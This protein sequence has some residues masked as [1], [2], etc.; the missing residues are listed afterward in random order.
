[1]PTPVTAHRR[2][3]LEHHH[4][5]IRQDSF[6]ST[7][8]FG[9][10]VGRRCRDRQVN[11]CRK[12]S[13]AKTCVSPWN[14]TPFYS[15]KRERQPEKSTECFPQPQSVGLRNNSDKKRK[16]KIFNLQRGFFVRRK[17]CIRKIIKRKIFFVTRKRIKP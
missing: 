6:R 17:T 5:H 1:M 3:N 4:C 2:R 14:A 15:M 11:T 16:Q 10:P 12:H 13:H 8:D 9:T 7:R